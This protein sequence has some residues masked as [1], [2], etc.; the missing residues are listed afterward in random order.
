MYPRIPETLS[1]KEVV[2]GS[3]EAQQVVGFLH[4]LSHGHRLRDMAAFSN[5]SEA[6]YHDR[7]SPRAYRNTQLNRQAG[8]A[9]PYGSMNAPMYGAEAPMPNMRFDNMRDGFGAPMQNTGGNIHFPYDAS[10]AQTWS[11]GGASLA[12]FGNGMG[13]ISQ[14]NNFGPSRSIK[15]SRGRMGISQV[16][17]TCIKRVFVESLIISALV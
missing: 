9:D 12:P 5:A 17:Y 16:S 15:P 10:A 2:A 7:S 11:A 13:N 4:H 8:G 3:L 1:Q 6:F 14:N